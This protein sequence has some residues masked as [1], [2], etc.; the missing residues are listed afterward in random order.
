MT[1]EVNELQLCAKPFLPPFSTVN[2]IWL[3]G[4]AFNLAWTLRAPY[5]SFEEIRC[6]QFAIYSSE[7]FRL[8]LEIKYGTSCKRKIKILRALFLILFAPYLQLF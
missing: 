8:L 1:K 7:L 6:S 5:D 4:N 2:Y 3:D